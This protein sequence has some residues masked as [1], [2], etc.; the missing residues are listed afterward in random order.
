MKVGHAQT[1]R[2]RRLGLVFRPDGKRDWMRTHAS[3]PVVL[4]L[5]GDLYR[6]Y[7]SSR[8]ARNRSHVGYC[9]LDIR[10]P[11]GVLRVSDAPVLA[12]G[13]LGFFD[14]HGTYASSIVRDGDR[15]FMYYIGWNPGARGALF[16]SSIGLA[17]S[18][19][20]GLTFVKASPAPIVARGEFDPCLVTGPFVLREGGVW[21]MWYVSGFQWEEIGN[22]LQSYYHVKYA[23][24]A[25]GITWR[26]DGTVSIGLAPGETNISRPC[27]EHTSG[28]FRMWY[29][30][31]AGTGYRIGYAESADGRQWQRL[32]DRVDF[33]ASAESWDS[34]AVA[35][36]AVFTHSGRR[37]M[38]YN[39]N[40]FGREGFGLA[41][42]E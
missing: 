42:E 3:A 39:G 13:P 8:D 40:D 24:S 41:V 7:F 23:E 36:P 6:I 10:E 38:T 30:R 27:V 12:P 25:D 14:D 28:I 19:D 17:V 34:T 9:E 1:T 15:L 11:H 16:Y 5:G 32:D 18:D 35:Y 26:R 4:P 21:R 31:N 2:W 33:D 20:G 37:Y 29:S 22:T